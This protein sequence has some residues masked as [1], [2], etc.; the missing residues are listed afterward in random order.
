MR[1]FLCEEKRKQMKEK[2]M[3]TIFKTLPFLLIYFIKKIAL[4][5]N[6]YKKISNLFLCLH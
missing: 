4:A 3:L 6:R 1:T 5:I 2:V